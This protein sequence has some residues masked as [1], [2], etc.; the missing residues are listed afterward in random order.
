MFS[1]I[2]IS[3]LFTFSLRLSC[4]FYF[5]V[6]QKVQQFVYFIFVHCFEF[7][8]ILGE[9]NTERLIFTFGLA[10]VHNAVFYTLNIFLYF[11]YKY[12]WF[13]K[14]RI[15]GSALPDPELSYKCLKHCILNHFIIFPVLVYFFFPLFKVIHDI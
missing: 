13:A 14:Y 7:I 8:M 5:R 11:C 12:N 1:H 9:L 15:Q 3:F 2:F 6:F 10:I 4:I